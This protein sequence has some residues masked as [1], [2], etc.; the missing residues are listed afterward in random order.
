MPSYKLS[1]TLHDTD[2]EVLAIHC[3][4]HRFQAGFY[5]FLNTHLEAG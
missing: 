3:S 5:E 1:S 4:D 2:A